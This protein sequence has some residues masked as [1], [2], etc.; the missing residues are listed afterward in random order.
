RHVGRKLGW[1]VVDQELMEFLAQDGKATDELSPAARRWVDGRLAEL[2]QSGAVS[3]DLAMASLA[4]VVLTLAATGEVILLGRGAGHI[5]PPETTLHVRVVAPEADRVAYFAQW[6][7]LTEEQAAEQVRLRD[8]NRTSLLSKHMK[9][10]PADAYAYD[11][12][13]NSSYLGEE[14]CADL[15]VDAARGK[16]NAGDDAI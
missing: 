14:L 2:H 7:R 4:R 10:D 5:L 12:I 3:T 1:Q 8:S 13:L 11:L 15:I 9:V 16:M 6:L